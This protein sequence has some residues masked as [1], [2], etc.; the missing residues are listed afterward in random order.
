[1]SPGSLV[2]A[3]VRR[4]A[5]L[6]GSHRCLPTWA[7]R[8][9]PSVARQVRIDR[10]LFAVVTETYVHGVSTRKVDDLVAALGAA[11]HLQVRGACAGLDS[12]MAAFRARPLGPVEFPYLFADTPT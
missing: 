4:H 1:M 7:T 12:E 3:E 2:K 11:S 10:A 6:T 8:Y 9:G 5:P